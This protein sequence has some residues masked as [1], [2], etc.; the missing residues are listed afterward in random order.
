MDFF[1]AFLVIA[2]LVIAIAIY[3]GREKGADT[4]AKA[5]ST[6]EQ[7]TGAA[8]TLAVGA[9]IGAIVGYGHRENRYLELSGW[10]ASDGG[11]AVLWA[12]IGA[13]L[14][15]AAIYAYRVFSKRT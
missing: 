11:E 10:L 12:V 2:A 9:V 7:K 3:L 13:F 5:G 1:Y 6:R 15:A 4:P 8:I 14:A